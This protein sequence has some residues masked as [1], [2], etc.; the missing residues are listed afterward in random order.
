MKDV[1]KPIM[2]NNE[3]NVEDTLKQRGSVYGSYDGVLKTR[4]SITVNLK[5]HYENVHGKKMSKDL[6]IGLG[7]IILKLVRAVGK[8]EYKDSWHD[9]QGYAK[10]MEDTY[11]KD[12]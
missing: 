8:P 4:A 11:G 5:K 6:E 12:S 9:L 3:G 10:L 1:N 7:D 2:G